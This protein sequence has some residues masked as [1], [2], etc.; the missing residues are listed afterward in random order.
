MTILEVRLYPWGWKVFEVPGVEPGFAEQRQAI[1]YAETH[2]RFRLG[3]IRTWIWRER[4]DNDQPANG[5][6]EY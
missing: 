4:A 5:A 2:A 1:C 6:P 3:E